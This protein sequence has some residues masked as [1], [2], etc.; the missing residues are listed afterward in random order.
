[1][2]EFSAAC[3]IV[4]AALEGAKGHDIKRITSVNI[5]LGEFTFLIPEQLAFNFEIASQNT[6]LEGAE[7]KISP[8]KGRLLCSECGYEGEVEPDPDVPEQ[9]AMFAPMKCPK[10]GSSATEITGGKEFVITNIEA[11]VAT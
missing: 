4:D 5:D 11:E 6:I 2:H 1:M 10:C 9:I 8:V 7:L 3:S